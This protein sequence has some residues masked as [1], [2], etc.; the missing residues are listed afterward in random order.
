MRKILLLLISFISFSSFSAI[1]YVTVTGAGSMNG[2]SWANAFPASSLQT[3]ITG[4]ALGDQV[5]VAAG[6]YFTTT[7][8]NRTISFSMR[9]DITIYGSFIGTETLLSQR[10]LTNGLT[11]ILS[12]EIGVAGIADNSYHVISNF[13]INN[14]AVIDGF[15]IRGANDDR[16]A[17]G[18]EGLGGGF[19]NNGSN[20]NT[21]SPIIRNCAILN[22]QAVFGAG[23]FNNGYNNGNA[24]PLILNCVIAYNTATSGGGG[25]DNFGIANGNASPTITNSIIYENTAA[26]RAGAMYCWGGNTGN[27]SPVILNSAFVNNHAVDGGG[28]VADNTNTSSGNSGVSNPTFRN[29]IVWGNTITGTGPQF[30]ILGTGTVS[31]TYTDID[32][33]NQ[34]AP[35]V[36]S[37]VTTGNLNV[38]PQF[39]NIA[40]GVGADT[41]WFTAD[42]GLQLIGAASPCY[43]AGNN[44]GVPATDLLF[45]NR[46]V[47]GTVDMGAYEFDASLA[48]DTFATT[49]LT[50]YP[51]P[52]K[53]VI[54]FS[55]LGD[56][57]HTVKIYNML[58]MVVKHSMV[59]NNLI[60]IN[61]LESGMYILHLE[62]GYGKSVHR[63]VKD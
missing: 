35:H 5:W 12:A 58:G 2:S 55:G 37:G 23:I 7:G 59:S 3:A 60:A 34:N 42:D 57:N 32:L 11:S 49:K 61:D 45:R 51:N 62:S 25:I 53:E 31:S 1:R 46:I 19:Y 54:N 14:T 29:S 24:S 8:T 20:G 18:D 21:C 40:L 39:M 48:T 9:N 36:L 63:I 50:L 52:T 17:A 30:F 43:D 38:N 10:D 15:I 28:V 22:N 47:N 44:T 13:N 41:K 6:T 26:F 33:T 56:G 27:T 16:P 4:A